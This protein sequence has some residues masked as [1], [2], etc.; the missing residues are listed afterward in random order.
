MFIGI[1]GPVR[2]MGFAGCGISSRDFFIR[3][4]GG[5]EFISLQVNCGSKGVPVAEIELMVDGEAKKIQTSGDGPVDAI[6]HGIKELVPH[7]GKLEL[8]Q[9]HAVTGGTD[10]QAEVTVRLQQDG[11]IVSGN[12]RDTDTLVASAMAYIGAVNKLQNIE[13]SVTKDSG[14]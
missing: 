9:V 6:F 11:K 10:A 14:V 3:S 7:N 12:S 4:V 1:G 2:S 8:Y 13:F 5:V